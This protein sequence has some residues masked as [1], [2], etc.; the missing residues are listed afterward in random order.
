MKG[1]FLTYKDSEENSNDNKLFWTKEED[2]LLIKLTNLKKRNNWNFIV[3]FFNGK[4][5]TKCKARLNAIHPQYR[6]GKWSIEEDKTLLNLI[7]IF[8]FCW[9]IISRLMKNRNEKQIRSRYINF[10]F[11]GIKNEK[12]DQ[13]EDAIILERF[14][15]FKT[16]WTK[17]CK[18]LPRRSPRQIENRCKALIRISNRSIEKL[19]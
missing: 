13:T 1:I 15:E 11:K 7:E 3:S 10:L 4:S 17:Y 16:K 19:A 18:Y 8:G 2:D 14:P 5:K 9:K 12:F 6:R